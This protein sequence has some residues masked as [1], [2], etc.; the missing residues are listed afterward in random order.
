MTFRPGV[1]SE[2][3][4]WSI[5]LLQCFLLTSLLFLVPND[6]HHLSGLDML[7]CSEICL[8]VTTQ[9]NMRL[10]LRLKILEMQ[11]WKATRGQNRQNFKVESFTLPKSLLFSS[12]IIESLDSPKYLKILMG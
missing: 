6:V 7:F 5:Q 8:V 10:L 4:S 1:K 3:R 12:C 11:V 2:S 9:Q